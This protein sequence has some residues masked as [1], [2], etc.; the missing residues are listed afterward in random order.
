MEE[1]D[2]IELV[3]KGWEMGRCELFE[4]TDERQGGREGTWV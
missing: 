2:L 3:R 4:E 1:T